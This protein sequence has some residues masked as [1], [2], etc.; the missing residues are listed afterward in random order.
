M[1]DACGSRCEQVRALGGEAP[2]G[3]PLS[4]EVKAILCSLDDG[5]CADEAQMVQF[6]R[7]K[8]YMNGFAFAEA[9]RRLEG[10]DLTS[11][12][13]NRIACLFH[14]ERIDAALTAALDGWRRDEDNLFALSW[15]VNM[16]LYLGD[17]EGASGLCT[18]LA[19]MTARRVDD[20]I[21]QL[22][23]LLLLDQP[24]TAW[25]AYGRAIDSAWWEGMQD[26]N[27]TIMTHLGACA[28]ARCGEFKQARRLWQDIERASPGFS[29][30]EENR[31]AGAAGE[32]LLPSALE[33]H[34]AIPASRVS[35]LR[36]Q[37]QAHQSKQ[38]E[39][40]L[41]SITAS[42]AYLRALY[43]NGAEKLRQIVSL[44]LQRRL[45]QPGNEEATTVLRELVRLPIG[46]QNDRFN[47]L[48]ALREAGQL[49][50]DEQVEYWDGEALRTIKLFADGGASRADRQRLAG[51]TRRVAR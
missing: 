41:T 7:A 16:R 45:Q 24:E 48:K 10:L 26:P 36:T 38:A 17:V 2:Y 51:R 37:V 22:I 23:A 29:L 21:P 34:N 18:R 13:N 1:L 42:S 47:I 11:A 28:A 33:M 20:A 30:A 3:F 14:L 12:R 50:E 15:A 46:T 39:N 4:D 43:I 35:A 49:G 5:T 25:K 40:T 9:L 6:D 27:S 32:T 19:M 8:L 44:V 31:L